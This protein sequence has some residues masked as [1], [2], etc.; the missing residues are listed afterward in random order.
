[1]LKT[2][3]MAKYWSRCEYEYIVSEYPKQK[4]EKKLDVWS[5]LE[6]NLDALTDYVIYK[7]DIKFERGE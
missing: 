7:M 5:Q 2:E 4:N 1:M 6:N 3:L